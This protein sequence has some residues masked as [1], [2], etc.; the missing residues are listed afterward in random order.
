MQIDGLSARA[1]RIRHFPSTAHS[2]DF[3]AADGNRF[4]VR[5]FRLSGKNLRV[6]EDALDWAI[7]LS[8]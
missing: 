3:I 7:A 8:P 5:M 1:D 6:V 2:H 4:G